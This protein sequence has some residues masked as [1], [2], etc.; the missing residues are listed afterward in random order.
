MVHSN[1][2]KEQ[3][4]TQYK[5]KRRSTRTAFILQFKRTY[6]RIQRPSERMFVRRVQ[7]VQTN[8]CSLRYEEDQA[9]MVTRSTGIPRELISRID[10]NRTLFS[11]SV[12]SF[13]FMFFSRS[14]LFLSC[15]AAPRHACSASMFR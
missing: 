7:A 15:R 2:T 1:L 12:K 13:M 4:F 3:T 5:V 10:A 9:G 14:T 11:G 6:V 8:I